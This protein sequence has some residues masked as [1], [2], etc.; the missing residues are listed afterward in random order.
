MLPHFDHAL[1]QEHITNA[2][3]ESSSLSGAKS[4]G[5]SP[6]KN[7]DNSSLPAMRKP[8]S[9]TTLAMPSFNGMRPPS[10]TLLT[11]L[12]SY[13]AELPEENRDLIRTVVELI[14][15]TAKESKETKMP[16]SNLLLV[17]CPSLNINPPLL[18]VLCEGEGIWD[19][20]VLEEDVLDIRAPSP[21]EQDIFEDARDGTEEDEVVSTGRRSEDVPESVGYHGSF[22]DAGER[23]MDDS[24]SVSQP[25]SNLSGASIAPSSLRD[26]G[27]SYVSTSEDQDNPS[28]HYSRINSPPLLTSSAESLDTPESTSS[29]HLPYPRLHMKDDLYQKELS[30][31]FQQQASLRPIIADSSPL[32]LSTRTTRRPIPMTDSVKF[33]SAASDAHSPP[34]PT[35]LQNRRSMTVL[36]L[37]SFS[38]NPLLHDTTNAQDTPSLVKRLR[39]KPSLQLLFSKKSTTSLSSPSPVLSRPVISSPYLQTTRASSDSSVSTPNSAVTAPQSSTFT[40]PS[41]IDTPLHNSPLKIEL[42]INVTP[43]TPPPEREGASSA[44]A[45]SIDPSVTASTSV[46]SLM[47]GQT[48]IADRF[49]RSPSPLPFKS[50]LSAPPHSE[51]HTDIPTSH[52]RPNLMRAR[53]SVN[54]LRMLDDNEFEEDWTRTVLLAADVDGGGWIVA[55]PQ[56][57]GSR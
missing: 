46:T 19:E 12:Q 17:L 47:S 56:A 13:L 33:P 16:L 10:I 38:P 5:G 7:Y 35:I 48:P 31:S 32:G 34:S 54:H 44:P 37:P 51:S 30:Y 45:L 53:S 14:K 39:N 52:L 29:A 57:R 1:A 43:S 22:E 8:P 9:L 49:Q 11:T 36:S 15:A 6:P 28:S 4:R 26:D 50:S 23:Y 20:I 27:S 55:K 3:N 24:S 2:A 18:K 25:A 40:L 42:G 41:K 21:S